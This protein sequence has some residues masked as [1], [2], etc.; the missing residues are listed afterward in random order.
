MSSPLLLI[1]A[2]APGLF[3][4]WYFWHRDRLEPEPR[5]LVAKVFCIGALVVIP[6]GL[7]ETLVPEPYTTV[8]AAPV[9]E[10]LAKFLV[11][12]WGVYR[13]LQF[14]EPMDG[15]VYATA[16]ALG[17][18]TAENIAY[19]LGAGAGEAAGIAFV[20]A[21]LSVP[22]HALW[23]CLWGYGLGRM[24][25]L[26]RK[27]GET[28]VAAGLGAASIDDF[29]RQAYI[30]QRLEEI[31][32]SGN[33]L[34]ATN[35]Q[36]LLNASGAMKAANEWL[37]ILK[38]ALTAIAVGL[39]PF[40]ALFIPTPLIGKALGIIAGFFIWLTAWGVTDAIV[41]QFAVDY[42]NRTYEMVRQNKL[43]M[44]A[45]YFFPDQTVK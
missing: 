33:A 18:A 29:L 23:G 13:C 38:A 24:K 19:V 10:E 3:W 44:D 39:L 2:I 42:A 21:I 15:I 32:R 41:H 27:R 12:F 45:L 14:D 26:D 36:F 28:F 16:A 9:F 17:F 25:F 4:L 8:L 5:R 43:G 11:V 40:L 6:A 37:P 31:F 35:Y 1:C 20:R 30:S 22:G 7:L 34:G